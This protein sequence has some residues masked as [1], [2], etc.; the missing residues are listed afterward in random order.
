M[1]LNFINN[2]FNAES[3]LLET[4]KTDKGKITLSFQKRNKKK[5]Y[6]LIQGF[7]DTLSKEDVKKFI[8]NCR[9]KWLFCSV[10]L[11]GEEKNVIQAQGEHK[12]KLKEIF[13]TVYKIN[14]ND[15]LIK[16]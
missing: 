3:E 14:D 4:N 6:T 5:G 13:K 1:D 10:T 12:M 16:G 7:V 15:I 9:K 2:N 8:K 11:V